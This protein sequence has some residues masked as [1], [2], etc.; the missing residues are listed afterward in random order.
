MVYKSTPKEREV[1]KECTQ[2]AF[3]YRA[4]PSAIL[5]GT[6]IYWAVKSGKL[7]PNSRF[8]PWPKV[9]GFSSLAYIVSKISYVLG[10]NCV[11]KFLEKAPDSDIARHLR[12]KDQSSANVNDSEERTYSLVD[13]VDSDDFDDSQLSGKE[14][15]ILMDCNATAF[16]QYSLPVSSFLGLATFAGVSR[17]SRFKTKS[18]LVKSTPVGLG[19]AVGYF[20]G[21]L[22]Y[23]YSGDCTNR[24]FQFAP[25]GVIASRLSQQ[26]D[27]QDDEQHRSENMCE[28]CQVAAVMEGEHDEYVLPHPGDTALRDL[29]HVDRR[30]R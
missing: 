15:Q 20:L 4:M 5:A 22:A 27:D 17:S 7:K 18:I 21:Q 19:C 1:M 29:Q 6:S 9:F 25:E 3:L 8:G 10:E 30:N 23:V 26:Y 13:I 16:Y 2:E 11:N 24:F 12:D 14:R 28:S